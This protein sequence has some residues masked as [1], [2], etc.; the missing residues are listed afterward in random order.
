MGT[1]SSYGA[2]N[3]NELPLHPVSATQP[4]PNSQHSYPDANTSTDKLTAWHSTNT[5]SYAPSSNLSALCSLL[6]QN[7]QAEDLPECSSPAAA[8]QIQRSVYLAKPRSMAGHLSCSWR[9][10]SRIM[11]SVNYQQAGLLITLKT[12]SS[13]TGAGPKPAAIQN[14][15]IYLPTLIIAIMCGHVYFKAY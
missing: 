9:G 11:L 2:D 15:H 12:K 5:I 13:P 4:Y 6:K 10:A 3:G 14:P 8:S 7:A 1:G